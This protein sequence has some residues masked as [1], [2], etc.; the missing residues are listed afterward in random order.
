[1]IINKKL[2]FGTILLVIGVASVLVYRTTQSSF[3]ENNI[4][5]AW[6]GSMDNQFSD[7]EYNHLANNYSIIVLPKWHDLPS[8]DIATHHVAAREIKT[9][10]P[11]TNIFLYY[12]LIFFWPDNHIDLGNGEMGTMPYCVKLNK[13]FKD[14]WYLRG[15][16]GEK[17]FQSRNETNL[18]FVDVSNP[19]YRS[20]AIDRIS[21]WMRKVYYDK[22][23][24]SNKYAYSGIAIDNARIYNVYNDNWKN[25]PQVKY[26]VDSLGGNDS[27]L[28]VKKLKEFNDGQKDFLRELNDA[29]G[30]KTLIFNGVHDG[31][32]KFERNLSLF[33]Y[34]DIALDERFC[35]LSNNTISK[36]ELIKD[37]DLM[38]SDT[39]S[40]KGFLMHINSEGLKEDQRPQLR[41]FCFASFLLGHKPGLTFVKFGEKPEQ[42][43][44]D[45][46]ID[47]EGNMDIPIEAKIYLGDPIEKYKKIGNVF[48]RKFEKGSI[49]VN[50]E[51]SPQVVI[52]DEKLIRMNGN[53]DGDVY[54]KGDKVLINPMD[55]VFFR[56]YS[57]NIYFQSF[58]GPTCDDVYN[59]YCV[60]GGDN[61]NDKS[62]CIKDDD[63]VFNGV[64][65]ERGSEKDFNDDG[66]IDGWCMTN[67]FYKNNWRDCDSYEKKCNRGCLANWATGGESLQFGEYDTGRETEC[68]G[69]D[70]NEYFIS[71][72]GISACCN[73]PTD[74]I[75]SNGKC[76]TQ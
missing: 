3:Q 40:S 50:M 39:Y 76:I 72:N 41:R 61:I 17:I 2:I 32:W 7:E 57:V 13:N 14:E 9:R 1:M 67:Y 64:C 25:I 10:N 45:G 24:L 31:N 54:E 65:Y 58:N 74:K 33:D 71:T 55:G 70:A 69:D 62:F 8:Q 19:E 30:D 38:N 68:C 51:N 52:L 11:K 34:A 20:W 47:D 15:A 73:N 27:D 12:S 49:F 44:I 48:M 26:L 5:F 37:I 59:E 75:D 60:R 4:F 56:K 53:E 23:S 46:L 6:A 21:M 43:S 63:C 18:Y 28:G 35:F 16:N 22:N 42:Y 36:D 29:L 66:R